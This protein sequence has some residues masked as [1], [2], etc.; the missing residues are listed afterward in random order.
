VHRSLS[1]GEERDGLPRARGLRLPW[2]VGNPVL[3][4]EYR[5]RPD[6]PERHRIIGL[7]S[8]AASGQ[9]KPDVDMLSFRG[10]AGLPPVAARGGALKKPGRR[11]ASVGSTVA[12]C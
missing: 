6:K 7:P 5:T 3:A 9:R 11:C 2:V 12:D 4:D 10:G 8:V 1:A